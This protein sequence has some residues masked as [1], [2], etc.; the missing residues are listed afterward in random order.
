MYADKEATVASSSFDRLSGR[1]NSTTAPLHKF[2]SDRCTSSTTSLHKFYSD[3]CTSSTTSLHKYYSDRC[4]STTATAVQVLPRPPHKFYRAAAP[5]LQRRCTSTTAP[6]HRYYSAAAQV[7]QRRCTSTT[8][9]GASILK[10]RFKQS[11]V[12]FSSHTLPGFKSF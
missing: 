2:Y 7:L 1:C 8:S 3:R 6:L 12:C 5:V 11:D 10:R 4:T 9:R